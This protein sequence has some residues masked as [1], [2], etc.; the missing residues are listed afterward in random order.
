MLDDVFA[1]KRAHMAAYVALGFQSHEEFEVC[2]RRMMIELGNVAISEDGMFTVLVKTEGVMIPHGT[3]VV[4]TD[5]GR[6][7]FIRVTSGKKIE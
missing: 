6:R 3:L 1:A 7:I 4:A 2:N 5:R